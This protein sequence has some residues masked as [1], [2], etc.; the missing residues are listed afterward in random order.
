MQ[1]IAEMKYG[2]LSNIKSHNWLHVAAIYLV[3]M[4]PQ[5]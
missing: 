3:E 5:K 4:I 2:F 1:A